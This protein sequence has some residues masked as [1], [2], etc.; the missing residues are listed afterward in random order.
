MTLSS[1]PLD[2]AAAPEL[3]AASV[4]KNSGKPSSAAPGE[5][6]AEWRRGWLLVLGGMAGMSLSGLA[7]YSLGLFMQPLSQSLGWSHGMVASA[8]TVISVFGILLTPLVGSLIDRFGPRAVALPGVVLNSAAFAALGLTSA[9]ALSWYGLWSFYAVSFLLVKPLVWSA[10]ISR[11]FD[12]GRGLALAVTLSGIAVS[13][14]VTPILT[15]YLIRTLGWRATFAALGLGWGGAVFMIAVF[16]FRLPAHAA[17]AAGH[18]PDRK[19][20]HSSFS[21]RGVLDRN[22]IKIALASFF[23]S[24]VGAGIAVN[25]VPIL[26]SFAMSREI[27]AQLAA[28]AGLAGIA[29]KLVTGWLMDRFEKRMVGA[30]GITFTGVAVGLL[31][32]PGHSYSAILASMLMLGFGGGS[33]LQI[34]VQLA[35]YYAG[36]AK[37]GRAFGA[38]SALTAVGAG[39][40]PWLFGSSVSWFGSYALLLVCSV[41][42]SIACAVLILMLDPIRASD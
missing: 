3:V 28:T 10:A 25:K 32:L 21:F 14:T 42:L 23:L 34:T 27:A 17:G 40:G 22:L 33:T 20:P 6:A 37:F 15:E 12:R 39:I 9:S 2:G 11:T 7:P 19:G 16:T 5:V 1:L 35:S 18:A 30:L 41:P 31:L 24:I 13:Q 4:V 38:I 29:G 8:L 26:A 36:P